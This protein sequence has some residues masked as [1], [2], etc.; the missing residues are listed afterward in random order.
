MKDQ[1]VAHMAKTLYVLAWTDREEEKEDG[2]NLSGCELMDV[3]PELDEDNPN[4]EL[5]LAVANNLAGRYEECNRQ[6]LV[7]LMYQAGEADSTVDTD[8]TKDREDFGYCLVMEALGH[9]VSWTD[10][11]NDFGLKAPWHFEFS[12]WDLTEETTED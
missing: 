4:T 11:H 2:M 1:I 8:S 6:D 5:C 9:G 3:A 12:H 10:R 7:V